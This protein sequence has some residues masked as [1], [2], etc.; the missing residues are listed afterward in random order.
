MKKSLLVVPVL[1][2]LALPALGASSFLGGYS[3]NIITPDAVIVPTGTWE[4]SYHTFGDLILDEDLTAIGVQYGLTEDL[5]VGVSFIDNGDNETALNAKYRLLEETATS[6]MIAV[7]V[8]DAGGSEGIDDDP[9]LFVVIS[10]NVTPVATDIVGEPSK[11]LRLSVGIGSGFFDGFFA[12]L[13]WTLQPR[14]SLM[15]EYVSGEV[16]G[17]DGLFN[18]GA[19]FAATD[20]VRVDLAT[21]DFDDFAFGASLRFGF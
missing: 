5:E 12:G 14:L 11:P 6:P 7:G 4:L 16:G 8:F 1:L 17:N 3:G 15:A 10:K 21:I 13:D 20:T 19:R 18:V 9:S 2:T